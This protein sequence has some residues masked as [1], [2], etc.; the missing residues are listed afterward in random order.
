MVM[1]SAGSRFSV[2]SVSPP[3]RLLLFLRTRQLFTPLPQLWADVMAHVIFPPLDGMNRRIFNKIMER[4]EER[5]AAFCVLHRRRG[6]KKE[7]ENH[8]RS[9]NLFSSPCSALAAGAVL[10]L[11]AQ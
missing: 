11:T 1:V 7:L 6:A 4:K 10:V 2:L 5:V 8:R 3:F 9:G